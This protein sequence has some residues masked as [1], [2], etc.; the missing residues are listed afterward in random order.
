MHRALSSKST[1][2]DLNTLLTSM[3]APTASSALT[4]KTGQLSAFATSVQYG[5]LRDFFGSVVK[6]TCGDQRGNRAGESL[7][8]QACRA[9][10]RRGCSGARAAAAAL[11]RLRRRRR[12]QCRTGT[13]RPARVSNRQPVNPYDSWVKPTCLVVDHQ[14]D[15]AA[16]GVVWQLAHIERLV[17]DALAC[18]RG[19]DTTAGLTVRAS[20]ACLAGW[21]RSRPRLAPQRRALA[22]RALQVSG[23]LAHERSAPAKAPSPC[24][25]MGMFLVRLWSSE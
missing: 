6:A 17:H 23:S 11:L 8:V 16:H 14:V 20:S 12:R 10:H 19:A 24:S 1:N 18:R 22:C 9:R 7:Q 13:R 5:L 21:R 4:W 25:R 15:G 2:Q 3:I